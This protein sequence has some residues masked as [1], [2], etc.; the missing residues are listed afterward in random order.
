MS[1]PDPLYEETPPHLIKLAR[2]L[3]KRQTKAELVLWWLVRSR[4]MGV[5][6]RRQHPID[7][8]VLDFYCHELRLAVEV[9]G[10]RHAA[11]AGRAR[12]ARRTAALAARGIQVLRFSNL[13][14]LQETGA[15]AEAIW[16]A[17]QKRRAALSQPPPTP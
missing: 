2:S 12:D 9:D 10:Y 6:F 4:Q 16:R 15:V 8:Y 11:T 5:K 3:R 13:E 14:V 17:C 7:P 1:H